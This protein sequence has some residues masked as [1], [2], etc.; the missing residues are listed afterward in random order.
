LDSTCQ[1]NDPELIR[2]IEDLARL[3]MRYPGWDFVLV[4]TAKTLAP[5]TPRG[6]TMW[7][8]LER[9]V[10]ALLAGNPKRE[11]TARD[12]KIR[13]RET[14]KASSLP[15]GGEESMDA[16]VSIAMRN[17]KDYG[18]ADLVYKNG[19][20]HKGQNRY[21]VREGASWLRIG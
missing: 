2:D 5:K 3:T 21:R 7:N 19:L 17:L 4:T 14:G 6:R 1:E 10:F 11:W 8:Q 9:D 15:K 20:G 12:M 13:L 18:L 16:G